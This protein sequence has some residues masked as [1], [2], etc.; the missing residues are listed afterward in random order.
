MHLIRAHLVVF[1]E[2]R[3]QTHFQS[4]Y[5]LL[6]GTLD[7]YP[8]IPACEVPWEIGRKGRKEEREGGE[9]AKGGRERRE[10][11]KGGKG[12][13][14]GKREGEREGREG[15]EGGW[16]G[17]R[18]GRKGGREGREGGREGEKGGGDMNTSTVGRHC[19]WP[20][21]ITASTITSIFQ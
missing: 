18:E 6:H 10:G 2:G 12:M 14:G 19:I 4:I 11:K 20:C 9:G 5:N 3:L 1:L 15:G 16:K 13:E 21:L 7:G 17:G 8:G